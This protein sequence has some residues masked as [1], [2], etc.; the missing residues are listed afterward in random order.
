MTALLIAIFFSVTILSG[1]IAWLLMVRSNQANIRLLKRINAVSEEELK[2]GASAVALIKEEPKDFL[3]KKIAKTGG[4]STRLEKLLSQAGSTMKV[5][6]L[7]TQMILLLIFGVVCAL[8]MPNVPL[9]VICVA[10][11]KMYSVV[12]TPSRLT[13]TSVSSRYSKLIPKVLDEPFP[14]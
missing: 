1:L 7:I 9:K 11:A 10:L 3:I 14:R 2:K 5:E 12:F 4:L 13:L 6:K 8:I